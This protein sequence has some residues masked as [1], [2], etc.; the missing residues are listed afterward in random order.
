MLIDDIGIV[1]FVDAYAVTGL[2]PLRCSWYRL[3]TKEACP[4]TAYAL[5]KGV[6]L[7]NNYAIDILQSFYETGELSWFTSGF[8]NFGRFPFEDP[9][10]IVE[11]NERGRRFYTKGREVAKALGDKYPFPVV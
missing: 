1:D 5:S 3:E 4:L 11:M 2:H 7:G 8:D 6:S 9:A 10:G